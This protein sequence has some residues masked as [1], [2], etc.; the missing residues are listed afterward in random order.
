MVPR[1]DV[2]HG[3]LAGITIAIGY[4]IGAAL[5]ALARL[6]EIGPAEE[7]A[8]GRIRRVCFAL[9][10]G[11]VAYGL[12]VL[13]D[14]A[15]SARA[16]MQ[17]SPV[18]TVHRLLVAVLSAIV[19]LVLIVLGRIFRRAAIITANVLSV[20]LPV[21]VALILG[22]ATAFALFWSIRSGVLLRGIVDGLDMGYAQLVS[23]LPPEPAP[24]DDPLKSGGLGSLADWQSLGGRGAPSCRHR[25]VAPRS[26]PSARRQALNLSASMSSSIRQ[27]MRHRARRWPW[28]N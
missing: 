18:D 2:I 9:A 17:M 10:A 23:L 19:A 3:V 14:W 28:P 6:M 26:P 5:A 25:P 12:W 7:H 27:R 20:I 1:S 21:R 4:L 13:P 24:P 8:S 15:N 16:A 11:L 22:L